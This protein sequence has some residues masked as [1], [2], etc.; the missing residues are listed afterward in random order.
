MAPRTSKKDKGDLPKPIV[1]TG[2]LGFYPAMNL[3]LSCLYN[4]Y[5]DV[6]IGIKDEP[7]T[8]ALK[9]KQQISVTQKG[10][11]LPVFSVKD[12]FFNGISDSFYRGKLPHVIVCVMDASYLEYFLEE[13]LNHMEKMV[14]LGFFLKK[15][16]PVEDLVPC[17][18]I[19]SNGIFF[20]NLI[21]K[22]TT[23]LKKLSGIDE[24]L[25]QQILGKFTRGILNAYEEASYSTGSVVELEKPC[26]IRLA[27]GAGQTQITIQS[28]LGTR[29]LASTIENTSDNPTERLELINA[30]KRIVY[31]VLPFLLEQKKITKKVLNSS[32]KAFQKG[33]LSMGVH[34]N[35]FASN[36]TAKVLF[37]SA[38]D[39]QS[40][41]GIISGD[42]FL[43]SALEAMAL[44]YQMDDAQLVFKNL[45]ER[46][47]EISLKESF[48]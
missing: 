28:I 33:V 21:N 3:S 47:E 11:K 27:G 12:R 43:L 48:A 41:S 26:F 2:T 38:D 6:V 31:S 35:A 13:F 14:S 32:E 8:L 19:A 15:A 20:N 40:K 39:A 46:V 44:H 9:T 36:E 24:R 7:S 42:S 4:D 45:K 10:K 17:F 34:R 25:L 37:G 18:I 5:V 30:Y 22:L 1:Q 16:N 23:A 29:G